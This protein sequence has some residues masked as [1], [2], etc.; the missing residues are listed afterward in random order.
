MTATFRTS[1]LVSAADPSKPHAILVGLPGAGKT[2]VGSALAEQLGRT[3]LDLDRE[4]ER[5]EGATIAAIFAE[6]GEH[7]FRGKER[8]LTEELRTLGNMI[9]SPGGGWITIPDVVSILRPP[10]SIIYLKVRPETALVRLGAGVSTRPLLMRPDPLAELVRLLGE[11]EA[12]YAGADH[13]VD[14]EGCT[15]EQ[16]AAMVAPLVARGG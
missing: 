13:S 16:V 12:L 15:V 10:A 2:V 3:F 1:Q 6:H 11:R 4:I 14:T 5:R 9:I 7:H 8:A